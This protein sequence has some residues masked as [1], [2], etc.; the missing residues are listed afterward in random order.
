LIIGEYYRKDLL[1][2]E[3]FIVGRY[4]REDLLVPAWVVV[5]RYYGKQSGLRLGDIIEKIY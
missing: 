5:G 1:V 3:W 4:Y 2:P